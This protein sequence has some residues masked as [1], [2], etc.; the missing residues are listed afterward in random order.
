MAS[1]ANFRLRPRDVKGTKL[2]FVSSSVHRRQAQPLKRSGMPMVDPRCT[3]AVPLSPQYQ[4]IFV[5]ER[6]WVPVASFEPRIVFCFFLALSVC[7]ML[8]LGALIT[9]EPARH[10]GDQ[11]PTRPSL[12][13]PYQAPRGSVT[14][15]TGSLVFDE[16]QSQN[17]DHMVM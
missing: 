5:R 10:L 7:G 15:S 9:F 14:S 4:Y 6:Q 3:T 2:C 11:K 12:E 8:V 13:N 16:S 1:Q 17:P